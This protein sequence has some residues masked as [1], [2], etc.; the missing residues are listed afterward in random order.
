MA[1]PNEFWKKRLSFGS[2]FAE[3]CSWESRRYYVSIIQVMTVGPI[4]LFPAPG[5]RLN[6]KTVFLGI[7]Y[8]WN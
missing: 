7:L 6:I 4:I 1:Y 3:V 5:P 2:T 8:R